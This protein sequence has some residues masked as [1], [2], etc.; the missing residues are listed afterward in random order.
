MPL[1]KLRLHNTKVTDLSPLNGMRLE[2]LQLSGLSVTDLSALHGMPLTSIRLNNCS[3]LTD[4]SALRRAPINTLALHDCPGLT[5]LSPLA[6]CKA[7][8][9]L[10]L[11][12]NVKD[13][14]FFR[15]FPVLERVSFKE[16]PSNGHRPDKTVAEF[17]KEH[18]GQAWLRTLR[19]S[20]V[21]IRKVTQLPDGT[22]DVDLEDSAIRDLTILSGAPISKLVIGNTS[23]A[24]LPRCVAC[25]S[26]SSF[27]PAPRSPT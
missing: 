24:D 27:S 5:D 3:K 10:T 25:H 1:K 18:D 15:S 13:F 23:V 26:S 8:T 12:P 20:G 22:W 9:A 2:F 11:P 4:L 16:D 6:D 17:W 21:T 7:L 14:E 19:T